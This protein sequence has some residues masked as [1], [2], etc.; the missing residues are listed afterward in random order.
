MTFFYVVQHHDGWEFNEICA[1]CATRK[2]GNIWIKENIFKAG[3]GYY[4]VS[5]VKF[6]APHLDKL[7]IKY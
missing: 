2:A 6:S 1:V 4:R 7:G 3:R 5:R